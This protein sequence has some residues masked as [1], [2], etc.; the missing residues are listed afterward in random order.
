MGVLL[1]KFH[2]LLYDNAQW[3]SGKVL[4]LQSTAFNIMH[5]KSFT[6]CRGGGSDEGTETVVAAV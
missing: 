6:T 1:P 5:L 4:N 3:S 2:F